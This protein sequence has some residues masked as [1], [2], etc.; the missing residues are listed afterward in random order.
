[1]YR[2]GGNHERSD[3]GHHKGEE[4]CFVFCFA[5]FQGITLFCYKLISILLFKQAFIVSG[6]CLKY[7]SLNKLNAF[8]R[9]RAKV[10]GFL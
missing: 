7:V 9:I 5:I 6:T 8:H 1:M 10:D 2:D 4:W 3:G